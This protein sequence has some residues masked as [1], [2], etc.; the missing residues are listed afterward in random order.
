MTNVL[1]KAIVLPL[2][3]AAAL[4]ACGRTGEVQLIPP[5]TPAAIDIVQ[6]PI[7]G[8]PT[9]P[10]AVPSPSAP[11]LPALTLKEEIA[12]LE[13]SG[14]I[15]PLDRS[16]SL[17]GPDVNNNGVRDDIEAYIGSLNLTPSQIKAA[18]QKAKALQMTLAVDVTD[19]AAVQKVGEMQMAGA[20]CFARS[21]IG[22][23]LDAQISH[24]IESKT[25]NTKI[26]VT[27]YLAYNV[28]RSGS[29]TTVPSGDTCEK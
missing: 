28:A 16:N 24:A 10:P 20:M 3:V 27:R 29:V 6:S 7:G 15:V 21:F 17:L 9:V 26:R 11:L 14:Q 4:T 23:P 5:E 19:T 18:L 2:A 25:A 8:T 1:T 22:N 13:Q 12:K